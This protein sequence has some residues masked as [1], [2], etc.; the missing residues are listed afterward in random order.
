M[1]LMKLQKVKAYK[2]GKNRWQYK[3]MIT[4]PQ[5]SIEKL[6]WK[7]GM[8]LLDVAEGDYLRIE[9]APSRDRRERRRPITT[10]LTYQQFRDKVKRVLQ[11]QDNG[12]TWSQIRETLKLD[13]VVPNNRWVNQLEKDIGLERVKEKDNVIIWRVPHV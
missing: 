2:L 11:Y 10:K 13:Q 9:V 5:T 3:Y 1:F 4:I 8:E 6:R 7:E 12:V